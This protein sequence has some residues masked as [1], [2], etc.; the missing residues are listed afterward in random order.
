MFC[1]EIYVTAQDF[2]LDQPRGYI[3][4]EE[5]I[6][7]TLVLVVEEMGWVL[8][9]LRPEAITPE[10]SNPYMLQQGERLVEF[11]RTQHNRRAVAVL[12]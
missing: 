2:F 11:A 4:F 8:G 3:F 5:D 10:H 12:N 1:A 9:I 6:A 7:T